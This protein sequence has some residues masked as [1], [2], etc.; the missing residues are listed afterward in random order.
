MVAVGKYDESSTTKAME[1][2]AQYVHGTT[3]KEFETAHMI[4]L[5]R[6]SAFNVWLDLFLQHYLN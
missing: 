5:E 3:L 4:N 6:P 2:V 1:Y